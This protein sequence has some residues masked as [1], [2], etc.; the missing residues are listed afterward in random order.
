MAKQYIWQLEVKSI[1]KNIVTFVDDTTKEYTEKQ[2]SYLVTDKEL[3]PT[4]MQDLV[5]RKVVGDFLVAC[6]N[7]NIRRGD[8]TRIL[9]TFIDSLDTGY[10]IAMWKAMW[11]YD[12]NLHPAFYEENVTMSL[13]NSFVND[14]EA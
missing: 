9:E 14:D 12:K 11:T 7:H 8:V 5:A 13:I 1:D 3:N 10:K 2:L 4:E 6:E